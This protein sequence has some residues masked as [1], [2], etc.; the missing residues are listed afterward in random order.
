MMAAI[1][2]LVEK[3][4]KPAHIRNELVDSF[5]LSID[6]VRA[7][8]QIQNFVY[9]YRR[10]TMK[11]TD[12]VEDMEEIAAGS[13]LSDDLPDTT[14]FTF[15]YPLDEDGVPELGD[16]SDDDPLVIGITT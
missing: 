14:P 11:N 8:K 1:R 15:G 5:M 9:N 3:D 16:G 2:E 10:S 7:L 13:Q 12:V 4:V 6:A